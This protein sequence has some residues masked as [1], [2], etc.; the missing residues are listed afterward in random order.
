MYNKSKSA[1]FRDS[2]YEPEIMGVIHTDYD[3]FG[4]K[5]RFINIGLVRQ[6]PLSRSWNR[7]YAQF[8]FERGAF[9]LTI[10]P[11]Y[12]IREDWTSDNNPV[13]P[14]SSGA[15]ISSRL[16]ERRTQRLT[17]SAQQCGLLEFAWRGSVGLEF[18][19]VPVYRELKGYVQVFSGY[20]ESLIDTITMRRRWEPV[21]A[22]RLDVRFSKAVIFDSVCACQMMIA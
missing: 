8:G 15:E 19:V 18:S 6:D 4:L 17:P 2:N 9:G 10:R 3:L 5:G 14:P 1:P 12:C 20:G 11:W 16:S 13:S 21:F 7:I 22:D